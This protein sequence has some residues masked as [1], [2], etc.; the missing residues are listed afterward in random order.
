[1]WVFQYQVLQT[2]AEAEDKANENP[3]ALTAEERIP[4]NLQL[5]AAPGFGVVDP[6]TGERIN[7]EL[8][9]PQAEYR[10]L[11]KQWE[12]E[13]ENGQK[14]INKETK[15]ETVVSLSIKDAKEKFLASPDLKAKSGEESEKALQEARSMVSAS[16]AGR[17]RTDIIR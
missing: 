9:E 1:M 7:L 2:Q 12:D 3:M 6:K 11:M 15:E 8:R 17:T 13:W 5:Q 14:V 16:S 10:E 4:K